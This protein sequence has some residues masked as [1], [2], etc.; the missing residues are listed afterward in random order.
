MIRLNRQNHLSY[1][2]L[3]FAHPITLKILPGVEVF[4]NHRASYLSITPAF[5]NWER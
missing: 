1:L 4:S 3:R 5:Q 2:N